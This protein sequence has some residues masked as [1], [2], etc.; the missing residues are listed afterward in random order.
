MVTTS[1]SVRA[2]VTWYSNTEVP[3]QNRVHERTIARVPVSTE[4]G[5]ESWF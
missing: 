3:T 2:L 1:A 5:L 4:R